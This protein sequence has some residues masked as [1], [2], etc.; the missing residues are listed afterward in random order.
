MYILTD[1]NWILKMLDNGMLLPYTN[2]K[3]KLI[4]RAGRLTQVHLQRGSS[5]LPF[6]AKSVII[7][8]VCFFNSLLYPNYNIFAKKG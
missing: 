2:N 5:P 7:I 3:F 1:L 8:F 4:F 6:F